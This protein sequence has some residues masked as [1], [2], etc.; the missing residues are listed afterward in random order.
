MSIL[1]TLCSLS[2][3]IPP[4][5]QKRQRKIFFH[6]FFQIL[7]T[8][9]FSNTGVKTLVNSLQYFNPSNFYRFRNK[10]T[11][12]YFQKLNTFFQNNYCNINNNSNIYFLDAFKVHVKAGFKNHGYKSRTNDVIV[13]RKAK[14]PIL[15]LSALVSE[16]SDS[17]FDFRIFKH[18]NERISASQHSGSTFES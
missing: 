7:I 15:M 10:I 12:N 16:T 8:S 11:D 14:R 2:K 13:K 5:Q 17:I 9:V 4:F 1:K 6:D 3:I 18:F